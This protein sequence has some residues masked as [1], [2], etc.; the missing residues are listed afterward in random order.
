MILNL[1]LHQRYLIG[2]AAV[3]VLLFITL[4]YALWQWGS[5]WTLAHKTQTKAPIQVKT[6]ETADI[7]AALPDEH[8][9][10]QSFS[11]NGEL[12]ITSLQLR[13]TGIVKIQTQGNHSVSKAYISIAGQP[14]KIYQ[15]GDTLPYGV[16]V[17][18]ILSDAI[19]LENDG[20][21]EKLPL[22]REKLEF[23]PQNKEERL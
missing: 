9:F 13:V 3:A 15:T 11:K 8:L 14:G 1:N 21:L 2:L 19:L 4:I 17:Y 5:D 23:K 12:P 22:P 18:D 7:I 10:G 20:Q 6:D 16:K